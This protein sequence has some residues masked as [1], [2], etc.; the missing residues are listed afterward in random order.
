MNLKRHL[1]PMRH[2]KVAQHTGKGA[3][4]ETLPSRHAITTLT[5]GDPSQRTMQNYEK[6]TPMANME[7]PDIQGM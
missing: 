5:R 1:R 2:V 3:V 4:Q 6:M 7:T